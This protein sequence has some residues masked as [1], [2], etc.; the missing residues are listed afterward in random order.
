LTINSIGT[1]N[2]ENQ[3]KKEKFQFHIRHNK[4]KS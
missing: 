4:V 3:Y 2:D 1:E